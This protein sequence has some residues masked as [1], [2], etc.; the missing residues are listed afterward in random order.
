MPIDVLGHRVND[1][2][3]AMVQRILDVRAKER[4][5]HHHHDAMHVCDGR[6]SPDIDQSQGGV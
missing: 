4:I 2:V 3:R 6:Y 1:N 5:I